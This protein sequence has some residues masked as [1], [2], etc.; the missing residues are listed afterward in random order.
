MFE[1]DGATW[2]RGTSV[3]QTPRG[4][5]TI[6][7]LQS[8]NVPAA[9]YYFDR[10]ITDEQAVGIASGQK[11]FEARTIPGYVGR[12]SRAESLCPA[13]A[14]SKKAMITARLYYGGA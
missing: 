2:H 7:H 10:P 13:W 14:E 8:L 6:T 4:E 3:V 12:L 9:H 1:T 11:G 5:R